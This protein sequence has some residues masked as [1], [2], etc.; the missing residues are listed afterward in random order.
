M[1]QHRCNGIDDS[2]KRLT[3]QVVVGGGGGGGVL[4]VEGSGVHEVVGATQVE[5]G[6]CCGTGK[7]R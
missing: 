6:A 1:S 3:V 7:N 2:S 5:V 4:L